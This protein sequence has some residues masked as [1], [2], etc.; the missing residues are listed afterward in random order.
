MKFKVGQT[1][2]HKLFNYRGVIYEADEMYT[3]TEDWYDIMAKTRPPKDQPWYKV[4]VHDHEHTTYVAEKNL[5]ADH[6]GE[7]VNHPWVILFFDGFRK[8]TYLG[9]SWN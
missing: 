4:L 5:E 1:I 6:S 8:G 3:G 2:R 7:P 9:K